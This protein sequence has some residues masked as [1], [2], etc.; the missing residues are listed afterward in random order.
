[1]LTSDSQHDLSLQEKARGALLGAAIGD[2]LGWPQ[3]FPK[4]RVGSQPK[5]R[6]ADDALQL[7][8]W[9]R[10]DGGQYNSHEEDILAGEYS[11]DTQLLLCTARSL[12]QGADWWERLVWRELP[13]WRLYERGGGSATNRAVN[14]WVIGQQPWS[15]AKA[16]AWH[17]YFNAGGNG[18]AMRILPH[19]LRGA[20]TTDFAPIACDIMTD[21]VCTHG[22]PRA[23]VGAL[24]YGYAVW[25]A[26]RNEKTL[27]YG[28]LVEGCL[29]GIS[30]WSKLPQ[31]D[32]V[33]TS[34]HAKADGA[35]AGRYDHEWQ[36]VVQEMRRL[37][38]HCRTALNQGAL[39]V[40]QELLE[41]LGCFGDQKGAGTI[42][43]AASILLASCFAA[44]P[45]HGLAVAA[46][47][48]G[49][50]TDTL[51]SMTGGLLGAV[52]GSE[53]LGEQRDAVQDTLYIQRI[54]QLLIK[55]DE[56]ASH[57]VANLQRVKKSILDAT[58]RSLSEK[59][60]GD[61]V[62]LPDGRE[63]KVLAI[64]RH[65]SRSK[66]KDTTSWKIETTDGQTL[67]VKKVARLPLKPETGDVHLIQEAPSH[68]VQSTF[69]EVAK[70]GVRLPVYDLQRARNFYTDVLGLRISGESSDRVKFE[71][72]ILLVPVQAWAHREWPLPRTVEART[73]LS[74]S[75]EVRALRPA[76]ERIKAKG[77]R[78]ISPPTARGGWLS[79]RC[80]DID[81]NIVELVER[82]SD[83]GTSIEKTSD[84]D[85]QRTYGVDGTEE[86]ATRL[87]PASADLEATTPSRK[88][89]KMKRVTS[90][91]DQRLP[92][93]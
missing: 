79:F 54:S 71:C 72:G 36:S 3:E 23:L 70:L 19:C 89:T 42:S 39:S 26:L 37:L 14:A 59:R 33:W 83:N 73:G 62:R 6:S 32:D 21:G 91:H 90:P 30:T 7:Q 11:D 45:R 81:G 15:Q 51:A 68:D 93:L 77:A 57:R 48:Y 66:T 60:I 56:T 65:R 92:L 53:W 69:I 9:I 10:R 22:H 29:E 67:Y 25:L 43:A 75:L 34:W 64:L 78:I 52:C 86:E 5:G 41:Q 1:M 55:P 44:D 80:L 27:S 13:T 87:A 40:D 35:F 18:V 76:F 50:D 58:K 17:Q 12:I 63:A 4:R 2:A 88:K 31:I 47:A 49:A 84:A 82:Q 16:A 74:I 20:E 61:S 38:D 46:Y 85:P 24:A 28:Q 8:Q